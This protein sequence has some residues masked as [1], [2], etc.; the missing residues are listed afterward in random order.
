MLAFRPDELSVFEFDT[1]SRSVVWHLCVACRIW[2]WYSATDGPSMMITRE[3]HPC[4][5]LSFWLYYF[6]TF[7]FLMSNY[8]VFKTS[9]SLLIIKSVLYSIGSL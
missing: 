2:A 6:N 1:F 8:K 7:G 9:F 5:P 3:F 4:E